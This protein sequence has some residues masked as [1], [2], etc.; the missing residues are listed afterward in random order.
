MFRY[1]P[2]KSKPQE[3]ISTLDETHREYVK[4]FEKDRQLL[5]S[6]KSYL[7]KLT[8][9][10]NKL[11]EISGD[12]R[13]ESTKKILNVPTKI[14]T[15][16]ASISNNIEIIQKKTKLKLEIEKI[17]REIDDISHSTSELDYYSKIDGVLLRYYEIIDDTSASSSQPSHGME[18]IN[19]ISTKKVSRKRS[20][21]ASPNQ[22]T[23]LHFFNC[24]P[25]DTATKTQETSSDSVSSEESE[26]SKGSKSS[27]HDALS[28]SHTLPKN[29]AALFDQYTRIIENKLPRKVR[30]I[31]NFCEKCQVERTLLQNDGV[32]VCTKCG[33]VESALVES[34][35]HNYKDSVTEKPIYPYKRLNHLVE[36]KM[37]MYPYKRLKVF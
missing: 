1:K 13:Q 5:E 35:V 24:L 14:T 19:T 26:R 15:S 6:K 33:E 7:K 10:F 29:R 32:Y 28:E 23:I 2:E 12:V 31:S 22:K 27:G 3:K 20:K 30:N 4:R 8:D 36:S 11:S 37:T 9:E 34:E 18:Q 16:Q 21:S 17:S 25:Q